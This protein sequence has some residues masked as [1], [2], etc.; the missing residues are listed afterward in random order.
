MKCPQC[1]R[2]DE[3]RVW[4]W[5][6]YSGTWYIT[7]NG[8][9]LESKDMECYESGVLPDCEVYCTD[10]SHI[11]T[12]KDFGI[13]KKRIGKMMRVR[14]A[15]PIHKKDMLKRFTTDELEMAVMM[16]KSPLLR[17]RRRK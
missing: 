6:L 13:T 9:F 7:G 4:G 3:F 2:K 1:G 17:K 10:C 5:E 8:G 12:L 11:G 14:K 15:P 16:R